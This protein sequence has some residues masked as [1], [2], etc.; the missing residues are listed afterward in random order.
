MEMQKLD[1]EI[2]K[3]KRYANMVQFKS[4]GCFMRSLK[5]EGQT[6]NA[7]AFGGAKTGSAKRKFDCNGVMM[8]SPKL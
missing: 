8:Q 1:I 4:R 2:G 6:V 3:T 7:N 5:G